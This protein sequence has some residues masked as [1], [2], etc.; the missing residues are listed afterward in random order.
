MSSGRLL[1][2]LK[3]I[4]RLRWAKISTE[5]FVGQKIISRV[6]QT[7]PQW[8]PAVVPCWQWN[9]AVRFCP[10]DSSDVTTFWLWFWPMSALLGDWKRGAPKQ[11]GNSGHFAPLAAK[12]RKTS[13]NPDYWAP[14]VWR[15]P[16]GTGLEKRRLSSIEIVSSM[17]MMRQKKL[18]FFLLP[19]L[20]LIH[21][22]W[23]VKATV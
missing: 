17:L 20:V 1:T 3:L 23:C 22:D 12:D 6:Q 11:S 2:L 21:I 15:V 4:P 7:C 19:L 9:T 5:S 8:H 16:V 13:G 18:T 14:T 10:K